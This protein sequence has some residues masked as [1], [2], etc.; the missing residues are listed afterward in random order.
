[1]SKIRKHIYRSDV[2]VT[3]DVY[4][5]FIPNKTTFTKYCL[6]QWISKLLRSFEIDW[7]RLFLVNFIGLVG[8]VNA[9]CLQDRA[10]F[11]R[12]RAWQ[13]V[14]I[15]NTAIITEKPAVRL[16][17]QPT[18]KAEKPKKTAA[19]SATPR[20]GATTKT[21][22]TGSDDED[23][24]DDEEETESETDTT[25]E[26]ESDSEGSEHTPSPFTATGRAQWCFEYMYI[27]T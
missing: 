7:V 9:T 5:S 23:D 13:T 11:D 27:E 4:R 1:M 24:D 18:P 14:L 16:K 25:T 10:N 2:Q 22:T 17:S 3:S 20:T 6:T 21:T 15:F 26:T 8:I 12:S 19:S